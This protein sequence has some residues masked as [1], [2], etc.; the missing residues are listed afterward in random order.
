MHDQSGE[1]A[2]FSSLKVKLNS[3]SCV[4][5]E[6][7][8]TLIGLSCK[9]PLTLCGIVS[10]WKR[11]HSISAARCRAQSSSKRRPVSRAHKS[12]PVVTTFTLLESHLFLSRVIAHRGG[13]YVLLIFFVDPPPLLLLNASIFQKCAKF[14]C[15]SAQK[16]HGA[17]LFTT[18]HKM[19]QLSSHL[20]P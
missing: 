16:A 10:V 1:F 9:T 2:T 11:I 5:L 17:F 18:T 3:N 14:F 6:K 13:K 20:L 19:A 12:V 7:N 15:S 4:T 8:A